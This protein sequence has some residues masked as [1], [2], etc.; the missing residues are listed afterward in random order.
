MLKN[1]CFSCEINLTIG[2]RPDKKNI[3]SLN[4]TQKVNLLRLLTWNKLIEGFDCKKVM[5]NLITNV[6]SLLV[7]FFH[8]L[9]FY[10]CI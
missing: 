1:I 7:I 2:E 8:R 9:L 4:F 5:K 3:G 10:L 6:K